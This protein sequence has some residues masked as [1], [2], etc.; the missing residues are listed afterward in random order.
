MWYSGNGQGYYQCSGW[1]TRATQCTMGSVRAPDAE[2]HLIDS[3]VVL[4]GDAELMQAV[5]DELD[6][7]IDADLPP[8]VDAE[9]IRAKMRRVAQLYEDGLKSEE[10]Y[11]REIAALRVQLDEPVPSKDLPNAAQAIEMLGGLPGILQM[12]DT[13]DRRAL[14]KHLFTD[15]VLEPHLATKAKARDEYRELLLNLD[16]RVECTDWWAGWAP[17]LRDHDGLTVLSTPIVPHTVPF[18][19]AA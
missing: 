15:I 7:L 3:L 17:A 12:A 19:I 16:V 4:T 2:K 14:L 9:A 1:L 5:V 13:T 18:R 8:P 11:R 6:E 10:A